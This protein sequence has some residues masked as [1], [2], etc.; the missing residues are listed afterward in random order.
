MPRVVMGSDFSVWEHSARCS[1]GS[2][3]R[4]VCDFAKRA[5]DLK[6]RRAANVGIAEEDD[7]GRLARLVASND[8]RAFVDCVCRLVRARGA[9]W[10]CLEVCRAVGLRKLCANF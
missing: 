7:I 6:L 4:T 5:G 3:F 9:V 10:S 2:R 8:I 1:F